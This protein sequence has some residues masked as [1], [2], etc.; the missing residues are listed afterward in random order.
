MR[1]R[2]TEPG[3]GTPVPPGSLDLRRRPGEAGC[4]QR[5]LLCQRIR[6][7]KPSSA[8]WGVPTGERTR[9]RRS[10]GR[11]YRGG[12]GP[13]LAP[14]DGRIG[15]FREAGGGEG[16]RARPLAPGRGAAGLLTASWV[17]SPAWLPQRPIP[18]QRGLAA[19]DA[20]GV[21]ARPT[22]S[23]FRIVDLRLRSRGKRRRRRVA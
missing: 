19:P 22:Q 1:A 17:V 8:M 6:F 21:A 12:R 20:E 10:E 5:R 3:R 18:R 7:L 2:S 14:P 11:R 9:R 13:G 16:T 23:L 15:I 4:M